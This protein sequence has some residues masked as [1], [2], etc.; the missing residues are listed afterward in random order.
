MATIRDIAQRAG[1]STATVSRILSHD[2]TLAVSSETRERVFQIASQLNYRPRHRRKMN[3]PQAAMNVGLVMCTS[4]THD[5]PYWLS[6]RQGIERALESQGVSTTTL[7]WDED[8]LSLLNADTALR[9]NGII[10]VSEREGTAAYLSHLDIPC[11]IVDPHSPD[12]ACDAVMIDF[13]TATRQALEHLIQLGHKRIGFIGGGR[14]TANDPRRQ[15]FEAILRD[16]GL[17]HPRY[18]Y[19]GDWSVNEGYR[20]MKEAVRAGKLPSAFFIASDP[21]AVGALH[22]LHEHGIRVPQDVS[23]VSFDGI[24]ITAY[25]QPPLTT[26]KVHTDVMGSVAVR[27]MMDRIAGRQV[28]LK[29]TVATTLLVREST[30]SP[31]ADR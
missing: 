27:L 5:D 4:E 30:T 31:A 23:V 19:L 26:V 22:A 21:L 1:V 17:Y 28:P 29:V 7:W 10:A 8:T 3:R 16:A 20:L 2:S 25:T 9:V 18:V 6:I 15:A 14:L 24:E 11:V 12:I 13:E